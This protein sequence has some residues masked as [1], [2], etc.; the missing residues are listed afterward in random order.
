[1]LLAAAVSP[2]M[3]V[4]KAWHIYKRD[5]KKSSSPNA[6]QTEAVCAGALHIEILGP[7][8]YFGVLHEKPSIG[9]AIEPV[10]PLTIKRVN[11]LMYMTAWIAMFLLSLIKLVCI[12]LN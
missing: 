10:N 9:E 8:Y 12:Y 5:R 6:G 2:K 7:A 1:M 4:R 11:Q 3:D